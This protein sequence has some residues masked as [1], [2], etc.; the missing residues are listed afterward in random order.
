ML[1]GGLIEKLGTVE[2]GGRITGDLVIEGDL[3]VEGSSSYVYD[4]KVEGGF[5]V[6]ATETEALL[7]RK[8]SDGGDVFTIDSTNEIIQINSHNGSSKGLK[9]GTT[10]VTADG[11]EINIL[12]GATL[13][14]A[15][16]NYVDGVTSAIQTQID[17]K[18]PLASPTFT[19]TITIG[20][21]GISE[22]ELEVLDGLTVSTAEVNVLTG[23]TASTAELNYLDITTLGTA[24]AS[25]AVTADASGNINFNNGNMTNVDIDSGAI[26]GTNI[27]VGSGKTLDVSGGTFTLAINQVSGDSIDGGT[28]STFASTG[29]DDNAASNAL[30]IDSSQNLALTSGTLTV[31]SEVNTGAGNR[32]IHLNPHGTGE[33]SVTA[34]LDATAI[35]IASGTAMTAI[36]DEDNMASDSAT[37]LATQQSIK[38][39]VDAVTTSLN[40]QDLDF[41]ADSGGALNI[42][43]DTESLTLTGGTGVVTVGSGNTVTFNSVDSEIV[44]DSLSGFVA[45]EHIAHSGV[46]VT[47]GTGLT[48]G[49][50]IAATRTLNVIGGTGITANAN[51]IATNDSEIVHDS[52]SGFVANEHIDHSGVTLTAGTG[53][54]GGGDLTSSRSFAVDLNELTTETTIA[55]ADFI[56]MVDAT[57]SGSGKITFENLEDAI[58]ASV[59]GD[60]LIT[61]AGVASIQTLAALQVDNINI[62]GNTISST[63]GTD[64]LITPLAGQQIVLDGTI[65]VDAGV[66]T[67][68]TS[69]TSTAFVGDITGDVTGNAD[70][71]TKI[72]SITNSNIVQLTSSQTLTNKTLTSPVFDTGVSGTAIKD[73]DTFASDSNTHLATQQSIKAYV[74][75]VAQGLNVKDSCAV[76]TTAN[77]TLSGEQSIDGV[78]TSTSRILVKN[79][80]TASQ[81]GIYVT[82][83]GAWARAT[84]FD[85]PSEV[86]SSFVFI[87]GGTAG[88]DTGWVCTNEPE[89]VAVG[90]DGITFSQFSDAG[91]I[92]AGT[93]LTKSGNSININATQS[94]ITSIGTL[95]GATPLVFEGGTPNDFETSI[96][97]TDPTADRTWTIPDASDTFVGKATTDTLTNKTLTSPTLV[98]PAL[99]TPA[100]GVATNITG[101][102]I[103]AGTTGTLSVARG[104]TGATSLTDGGVLLGSGTGAVTATAVL[105]DGEILVGDGTTDPVALDIGSSTAITTV[106]ALGAGGSITSG[107]GTIDTGSSTITTTGTVSTGAL[108]VGGNIDFNS[109][110][111]DLSTQTVD[112]TLNAAVDALNFDSNTLSIDASNNRVGIGTASPAN[113]LEV[114]FD[115]STAVYTPANIADNTASGIVI[116]NTGTSVGRGGMLKFTSKDGDNMTAIV[117]TQEGNDSASLRFF[118]ES[119]GTLAQRLLIDHDGTA[120]FAGQVKIDTTQRYFTKWESTYGTD[121]DYWWRNDSGLLQ[122]GEGAE[123]DSQ[124]K[125][126]FDTANKRLGIGATAPSMKLQIQESTHGANVGIRLYGENLSGTAQDAHIIL[127]PDTVFFGLSKGGSTI[128]LGVNSSGNVGIG[129]ASPEHL[130]HVEGD[131]QAIEVHSADYSNI[132]LGAAGSV[133]TAIA[134]RNL[135]LQPN[136][137]NVGIGLDGTGDNAIVHKLQVESN[138]NTYVQKI[139]NAHGSTPYGLIIDFD[140][141]PNTTNYPFIA[142]EAAG[143]DRFKIYSDGSYSDISDEREKENI[144][145]TE[146][147]LANINKLEIKDYNR[148]GDKSKGDH[149]GVIAQQIEPIY[150]HLV[151]TNDDEKETKMVYKIGLIAPLIKAV[152]ELSASND[153]LKSR[154]ETLEN[155]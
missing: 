94:T 6:D 18:A 126:T 37:S 120:T 124:V 108:T 15:E 34:T 16:L 105:A 38:A 131:N 59:S 9:L 90:T 137:S 10:L 52:L 17:T 46:E 118:T 25:K 117:H 11:G 135:V 112:V 36:K 145:D 71:A 28:I 7:V 3:T 39:Y 56:A 146:S 93:G 80:S 132:R 55:D 35:K 51:D 92:T 5:I 154:I 130:L 61:E 98:T 119:G 87:S 48:G 95:S 23:I 53:L 1:S 62:N 27:T 147:Q 123:G 45:D 64:L 57:D 125:F 73:E 141:D 42:D 77:I 70:T 49:G 2:A 30:T 100:S 138:A 102:P 79:Q 111:I 40:L 129:T 88:A 84:D 33:V 67:G 83:A 148:I 106:G 113:V 76:A 115:D 82:A 150:P 8:A 21:A 29:I 142:G 24:Q 66:L 47:A 107:F 152:Q 134:Y 149:I 122:L 86:A 114:E 139:Q 65:V 60:V 85:A 13:S 109:G 143:T 140:A 116:N 127:D 43:L 153:A 121:R 133:E 96:S 97:V 44:H 104:G 58:F 91:H 75:S 101:L 50:T 31:Y 63:A 54:S 19:G 136:G 103:V 128:D 32:D 22:A 81:N 151:R 14:T 72:T 155:A 78:T 26:D 68:A 41:S 4:Q 69:V 20:S 12:D 99:G 110:T 89:S 144:K 74:D